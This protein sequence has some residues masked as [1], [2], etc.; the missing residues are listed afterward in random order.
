MPESCSSAAGESLSYI[1]VGVPVLSSLA[2]EAD[3]SV[4]LR[5]IFVAASLAVK[6]RWGHINIIVPDDRVDE[7]KALFASLKTAY[8]SPPSEPEARS[9]QHGAP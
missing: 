8:L 2:D 7:A 3:F 6:A 5:M 4:M 1:R 9:I